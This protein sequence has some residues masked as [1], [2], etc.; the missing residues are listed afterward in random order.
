M[1]PGRTSRHTL[2]LV[3]VTGSCRAV[4]SRLLHSL[5]SPLCRVIVVSARLV[6]GSGWVTYLLGPARAGGRPIL[7]LPLPAASELCVCVCAYLLCECVCGSE[8]LHYTTLS[9]SLGVDEG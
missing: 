6:A 4:G 2:H 5:L 9:L 8:T 7:Y 1:Q 3:T